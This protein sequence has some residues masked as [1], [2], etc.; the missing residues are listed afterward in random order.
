MTSGPISDY[1][2]C[3]AD[4]VTLLELKKVYISMF[5]ALCPVF[6][7]NINNDIN[8]TNNTKPAHVNPAH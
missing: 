6:P 3:A 4:I 8:K 7:T 5:G 2:T 1:R